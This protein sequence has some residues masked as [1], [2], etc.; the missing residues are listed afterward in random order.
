MMHAKGLDSSV[1]NLSF[2][3]LHVQSG[4]IILF[5]KHPWTAWKDAEYFSE[6]AEFA[7]G[8]CIHICSISNIDFTFKV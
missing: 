5:E 3:E 4:H 8:N 7:A 2:E 6:N 1:V